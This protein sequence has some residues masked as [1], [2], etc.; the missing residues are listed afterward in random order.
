MEVSMI[1][2]MIFALVAIVFLLA[3]G[4]EQVMT[5]LNFG[6]DSAMKNQINSMAKIAEKVFWSSRGSSDD[7]SFKLTS[8]FDKACFLNY[9]D[10][11]PNERMGWSGDSF[12]QSVVKS[13]N[14]TLVVFK[15]DKTYEV[16]ELKGVMADKSFCILKTYNLVLEN[17]GDHVN[18]YPAGS[19]K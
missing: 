19:V 7:L 5:V 9:I 18:V 11:R 12:V 8:S 17:A 4:M 2:A 13:E 6:G 16:Y 10:P 15:K 3:G 1:F 14:K